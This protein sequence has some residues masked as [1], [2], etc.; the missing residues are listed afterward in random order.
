MS[1]LFITQNYYPNKGGMAASCDR[2]IRNFRKNKVDVHVLHFTNRRKKFHTEATVQ[3]S[4]T[5]L[6]INTS[7][8]FTL[9]LAS[10]FIEGF[11]ALHAIKYVVAFGGHLPIG[12]GPIVSKWMDKP[13][14]TLIRG[15][16]FDEAIFSKRREALIYA[17]KTSEFIFSV[18]REK[19]DKIKKLIASSS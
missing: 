11:A 15:N 18:T 16:D 13:L 1:L 4:Y 12:L 10:L 7:E 5:T 2:L 17:L 9:N 3:G 6:P 19:R 14:V 8:E